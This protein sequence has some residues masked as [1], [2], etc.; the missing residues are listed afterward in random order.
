[1]KGDIALRRKQGL[2]GTIP[3]DLVTASASGLDPDLSP[4]AALIQVPRVAKVR[5]LPEATV[6]ALVERSIDRP[7]LWFVGDEHVNVL[8]L[9][10]QLDGLGAKPTS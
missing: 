2:T 8:L 4:A 1:M 3:A 7:L 6:R 5:G 10:R 9:N